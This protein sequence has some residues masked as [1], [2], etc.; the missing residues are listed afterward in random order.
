MVDIRRAIGVTQICLGILLI[1]G[2]TYFS[3]LFAA[4]HIQFTENAGA[5]FSVLERQGLARGDPVP[6]YATVHANYILLS[7]LYLMLLVNFGIS[8]IIILI[9]IIM[10]LQGIVNKFAIPSLR[11]GYKPLLWLGLLGFIT[12]FILLVITQYF[13]RYYFS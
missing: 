2:T 10:I 8:A 9:G 11:V 4:S 12:I 13:V 7:N 6:E 5:H 3:N 1:I